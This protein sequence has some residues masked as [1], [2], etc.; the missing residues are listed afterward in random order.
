MD[1]DTMQQLLSQA[2]ARQEEGDWTQA[3]A[4]YGR[5][6]TCIPPYTRESK[7][8]DVRLQALAAQTNLLTLQENYQQALDLSER[9]YAEATSDKHKLVALLRIANSASRTG[10]YPRAIVTC[11]EALRL[12]RDHHDEMSKAKALT[13]LGSVY[14]STDRLE[15]AIIYFKKSIALAEKL[16]DVPL[17][18]NVWN[19]LGLAYQRRGKLSK[20][21]QCHERNLRL[22]ASIGEDNVTLQ[23]IALNNLGEDYLF[24]YH[25][26]KA[27]QYFQQGLAMKDNSSRLDIISDLYRN[28]GM[29]LCYE[30]QAKAGLESL[31][32]A[33]QLCEQSHNV[34]LQLQ[35]YYSLALAELQA[36][37]REQAFHFAQKLQEFAERS[38]VRSQKA[39]ALYALGL[40]ERQ[41]G[42][43]EQ[44]KQIL[45]EALFLAHETRQRFLRWQIHAELAHI[46]TTP[47]LRDVHLRLAAELIQ[48]I[49]APLEDEE[50]RQIF[51]AAPPVQN[52]L[53]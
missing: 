6:L 50:L 1:T 20:A 46:A 17:Q 24:L 34:N 37:N 21:I 15:D 3:V 18:A 26:Q 43:E 47:G 7:A 19:R 23:M 16:K 51:L 35:A 49:A 14:T 8:I 25:T 22:V 52:V 32:Q 30:Y 44:A 45:E 10:Y 2:Q 38:S 4:I 29:A 12:A 53:N 48:E 28:Q 31:Y 27:M 42:D 5:I 36:D 9:F 41:M 11:K 39:K 33:L 40:Y 13:L